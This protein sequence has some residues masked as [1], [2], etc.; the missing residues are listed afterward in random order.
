MSLPKY[1]PKV[2]QKDSLRLIGQKV[3]RNNTCYRRSNLLPQWRKD[4][5]ITPWWRHWIPSTLP[6]VLH[7]V[8]VSLLTVNYIFIKYPQFTAVHILSVRWNSEPALVSWS[9]GPGSITATGRWVWEIRVSVGSDISLF[10][11]LE[12]FLFLFTLNGHVRNMTKVYRLTQ[13]K[14]NTG[15]FKGEKYIKHDCNQFIWL[16][17]CL[18]PLPVEANK[19]NKVLVL[20]DCK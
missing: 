14:E 6:N 20:S 19:P 15:S 13:K 3:N 5:M 12:Y 10:K 8:I 11:D 1:L 18:A 9:C 17:E 7:F 2:H 16:N 4:D